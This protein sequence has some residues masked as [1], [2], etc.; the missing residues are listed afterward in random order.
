[1]KIVAKKNSPLEL[2]IKN[3]CKDME[4]AVIDAKGIVEKAVGVR[5]VG[6][7]HI[8]HWGTISHLVPEF[9][10]HPDDGVKIDKRVLRRK[11][12]CIDI[13][14]PAMKYRQGKDLDT[15]FRQFAQEHEITD[16]PLKQFGIETVDINRGISCYCQP[17]Y[18][19]DADR[20]FLI[21][22]E[23]IIRAFNKKKLAKDQFD[24]EYED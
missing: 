22:S 12:G 1:M 4:V 24:I 3:M 9:D 11:K 5:P 14:V 17:R 19:V 13:Y 21:C 20:Y 15:T 10:F 23:S 7:F 16:D 8:Y 2:V 18:D 6:I